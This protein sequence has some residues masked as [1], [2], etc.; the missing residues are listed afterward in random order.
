MTFGKKMDSDNRFLKFLGL[1]AFFLIFAVFS[2]IFRS[3]VN[4]FE[5]WVGPLLTFLVLLGILFIVKSF[6]ARSSPPENSPQPTTTPFTVMFNGQQ[7][8]GLQG[9]PIGVRN[10]FLESL[11]HIAKRFPETF[12]QKLTDLNRR[13]LAAEYQESFNLHQAGRLTQ[14]GLDEKTREILRKFE[15][16]RFYELP[17]PQPEPPLLMEMTYNG[18]KY[19]S[20]ES[21][22]PQV[23]QAYNEMLESSSKNFPETFENVL[24]KAGRHELAAEL[25]E[26]RRLLGLNLITSDEFEETRQQILRALK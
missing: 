21:M 9:M 1:F 6:K 5:N 25:K 10:M 13:D 24:N 11:E 3:A 12:A 7:Y 22:P 19:T 20:L 14:D 26:S 15:A 4:A 17:A 2:A 16:G 18:Q 23:R 8:I